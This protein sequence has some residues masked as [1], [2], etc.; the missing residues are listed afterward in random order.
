MKRI[1]FV[2]NHAGFMKFNAP[3]I[4]WLSSEGYAVDNVSPGVEDSY[5]DVVSKHFDVNISR[6][7]LSYSNIKA[8]F[9]VR[10]IL[11]NN[12]YEL[13]HCHTPM[14]AVVARLAAIGMNVKVLYT[15]HGYH[16]YKNGPWL[17]WFLYY[18]IERAL[19]FR[20]D[21]L[22]TINQEDF[23]FAQTHRMS[24]S[25]PYKI[26]GVGFR[27]QF[28][29]LNLDEKKILRQNMGFDDDEY[30]VLYTAQ[31]IKR[32]NHEFIIECIPSLLKEIKKIKLVFVGNG[33]LF[34]KI[35]EK[36]SANHLD[37]CVIFM[38]G[39]NDV[40]KFCQIADIYI[41]SSLQEGLCVSNLEAMACG[42]PLVL[43]NIRGQKDVCTNS[44]NGF[45]YDIGDKEK[46]INSIIELWKNPT[47]CKKIS[48]K[49]L[50]DVK[51]FSLE[52]SLKDMTK[53][54]KEILT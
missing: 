53:I 31:F 36:V 17:G 6:N 18:P 39:R 45:L 32:K 3:Y 24:I 25:K 43:S 10:R 48:N 8:I 22:V 51:K 9:Q 11:K 33:E 28:S 16:F 37:D 4:Q 13:I 34:M 15:V 19:R 2:S 14:G 44:V 7:P 38:G 42:L 20:T 12:K 21:Y 47:I 52:N 29:M 41:S 46:F 35:K 27:P 1:L 23:E 40:Y 50:S 5:K 30:I 54:Y 49:N 26:N